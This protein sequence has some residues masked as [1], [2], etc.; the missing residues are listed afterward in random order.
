MREIRTY[1][2]KRGCWP[3]RFARRAG[4]YSTTTPSAAT[5]AARASRGVR[6]VLARQVRPVLSSLR[7]RMRPGMRPT[8]S[9]GYASVGSFWHSV[10]T[11]AS[12]GRS[13]RRSC[14]FL[15]AASRSFTRVAR[16]LRRKVGERCVMTMDAWPIISY[17]VRIATPGHH[18]V[19]RE[20]V[21]SMLSSDRRH[22]F[23]PSELKR[24]TRDRSRLTALNPAGPM[25]FCSCAML[26]RPL[27]PVSKHRIE[28][29]L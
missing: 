15:T 25:A 7:F 11:T 19:T 27:N 12:G 29:V 6:P 16:D 4:V 22:V 5:V 20:R 28:R 14:R 1:G 17:T 21:P 24:R 18:L 2:L 13:P 3:G 10:G 23:V 9:D 8:I 26:S